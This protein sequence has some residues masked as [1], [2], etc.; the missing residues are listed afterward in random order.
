MSELLDGLHSVRIY[1]DNILHVDKG[2]WEEHLET[3]DGI[4][5]RIKSAGPKVN[6]KKSFFGINGLEYLGYNI[7]TKGISPIPK[8]VE[9]LKAIQI[10]KTRRQLRHFIG[11]INYYRDMWQ[12]G[13]TLLAP[14]TALTSKDKPFKWTDE[15]TTC[16][17]LSLI[18]I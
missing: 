3:L 17:N 4:L 5:H 13:S 14:L 18:H 1:I 15:H 8:K 7:S 6:A 9:A 12:Q 10:P 2:T 16:F 11:M